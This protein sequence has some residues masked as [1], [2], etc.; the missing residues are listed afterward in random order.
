[1]KLPKRN[2]TTEQKQKYKQTKQ[3]QQKGFNTVRNKVSQRDLP[4]EGKE[5]I[6]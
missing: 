5:E 4:R 6:L 2:K 1:M 3:Q